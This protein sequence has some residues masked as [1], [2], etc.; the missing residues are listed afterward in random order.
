MV[1]VMEQPTSAQ[2][3][4]WRYGSGDPLTLDNCATHNVT[5]FKIANTDPKRTLVTQE[6]PFLL[7]CVR[8]FFDPG[9]PQP[10]AAALDW[11]KLIQLA[12]RHAVVALF[13]QAIRARDDVPLDILDDLQRRALTA[14][15][16]DLT[17]SA[18]L[19]R[20]L[21]LFE[22]EEIQVVS[23]KGPALR[24]IL[25]GDAAL[26]SSTDL[27]FLVRPEDVLRAKRALEGAGYYMQS[28]LPSDADGA[29]LR[30]RDCQ[31]TLSLEITEQDD[32]LFVDLHWRLLPG[33]FP[34]FFDEHALW[35][36]LR[37]VSVA[38]TVVPTFSSE[39]LLLFLCA[40]GTKHLWQ[41][42][43]WLC[44]IARLVQVEPGIDWTRVFSEARQ[45]DTT[46]MVV[47]A[48]LLAS[49]LL[50]ISIPPATVEYSNDSGAREL[51]ETIRQ[52]L[53]DEI[54]TPAAAMESAS[55]SRRAFESTGH[56]VRYLL[57][58]FLEPTE[59]EYEALKLPLP[60]HWLYYFFRPL[61]LAVKYARLGFVIRDEPE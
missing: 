58:I 45:T 2:S 60:L 52:R 40:H 8:R 46:R 19:G 9:A 54:L 38:G 34:R 33:Y 42:L 53:H 3:L 35:G 17:L 18:E 41:R 48:L 25:Y 55:F 10:T 24:N 4:C 13:C 15:R 31:I 26:R 51:V 14:A 37:Q 47:L 23:L 16:F 27:D 12:E 5:Q 1:S 36:H 30:R 29:C 39:H 44:D 22:A 7:A 32:L 21:K 50:G 57:G 6:F 28:I 61:R 11:R 56:R 49:E 59:A 43:G 20:L